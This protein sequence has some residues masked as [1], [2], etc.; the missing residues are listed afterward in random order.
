M[1]ASGSA[2]VQ[3]GHVTD[4]KLSRQSHRKNRETIRELSCCNKYEIFVRFSHIVGK[5]SFFGTMWMRYVCAMV[6]ACFVRQGA[7]KRTSF[8]RQHLIGVDQT[9]ANHYDPVADQTGYKSMNRITPLR[10]F[11]ISP[12]IQSVVTCFHAIPCCLSFCV[13]I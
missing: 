10:Y 4:N 5:N 3:Y 1:R 7:W 9:S 12:F 6:R 13:T 2:N 11:T 8:L